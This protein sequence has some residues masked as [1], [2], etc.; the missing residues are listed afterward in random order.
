MDKRGHTIDPNREPVTKPKWWENI[1]PTQKPSPYA[2]A[3]WTYW[4]DWKTEEE[5]VFS[6]D[7]IDYFLD[8]GTDFA[9]HLYPVVYDS[10]LFH[11]P[12][13]GALIL[14]EGGFSQTGDPIKFELRYYGV[15]KVYDSKA[16][17]SSVFFDTLAIVED[18]GL[19]GNTLTVVDPTQLVVLDNSFDF[20]FPQ[21]G[22]LFDSQEYPR[23]GFGQRFD[24]VRYHVVNPLEQVIVD[25]S[26]KEVPDYDGD[27]FP[28]GKLLGEVHY[29][30]SG[31]RMTITDWS[32]YNWQDAAP[33]R[34]AVKVLINERP[35]CVSLINVE[36][37][38]GPFWRSMGFDSPFKGSNMLVHDTHATNVSPY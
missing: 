18:D 22:V 19:I 1:G 2:T 26:T 36:D 29:E 15:V 16:S 14:D 5:P 3:S 10:G 9:V 11:T 33:V 32:H 21:P 28:S 13:D 30:I 38:P 20:G 24:E 17:D 6:R 8:N 12:K 37:D 31:S 25:T 34:K 4:H 23:S 7:P 27:D 35:E